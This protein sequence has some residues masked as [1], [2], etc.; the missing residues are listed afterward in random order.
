M[1][2]PPQSALGSAKRTHALKR[3]SAGLSPEKDEYH[4][5]YPQ[6]PVALTQESEGVLLPMFSR[7]LVDHISILTADEVSLTHLSVDS[8][9]CWLQD[10]SE[11]EERKSRQR[12]LDQLVR[13]VGHRLEKLREGYPT[14]LAD[15]RNK[16]NAQVYRDGQIQILEA[17]EQQVVNALQRL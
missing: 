17:A 5:Y 2:I 9:R 11:S 4:I 12:L 15:G 1:R 8:S 10:L 6:H 16:R 14:G 3:K 7:T 13:E